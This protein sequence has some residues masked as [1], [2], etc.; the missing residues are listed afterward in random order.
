MP[1]ESFGRFALSTT[2]HLMST[3]SVP[4]VVMSNEDFGRIS[5]ILADGTEVTLEFNIVNRVYPEGTTSYNTV[6]EIPRQRQS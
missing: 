6:A 3:K 2:E 4:T 1:V 5:R